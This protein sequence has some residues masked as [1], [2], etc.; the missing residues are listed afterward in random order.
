MK[1]W[2][3]IVTAMLTLEGL[4]LADTYDITLDAEGYSPL[5]NSVE[6]DVNM[7]AF[8]FDLSEI[9]SGAK[10]D[11]AILYVRVRLDSTITD[12]LNLLA[13]PIQDSWAS[14]E[15]P[16]NAANV[17][18]RDTKEYPAFPN[19]KGSQ[20]VEFWIT[21]LVQEWLAGD[22]ANNG[23]II[24]ILEIS[25]SLLEVS[26]IEGGARAKLLIVYDYDEE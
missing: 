20:K 6:S 14:S 9:P 4:S 5:R 25:E 26:D 11:R 10:I 8:K 2:I 22:L 18:Y 3:Y 7:H 19:G 13:C 24:K 23:L 16:V 21:E 12:P 15:S 17:Q 1:I